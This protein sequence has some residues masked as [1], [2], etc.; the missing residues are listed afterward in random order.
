MSAW[1]TAEE[2]Y[3]FTNLSVYVTEGVRKSATAIKKTQNQE[4]AILDKIGQLRWVKVFSLTN[5]NVRQILF[6]FIFLFI[7]FFINQSNSWLMN[8]I[9]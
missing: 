6:L 4:F 9:S 3:H 8:F 5:E 1:I 2:W 7:Y